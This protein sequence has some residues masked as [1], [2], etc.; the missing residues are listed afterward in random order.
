M[1]LSNKQAMQ[2]F[3]IAKGTLGITS[4]VGNFKQKTRLIII[5]GIQAQQSE[6]L[7]DLE[8]KSK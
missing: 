7:K 8:W 5:N 6:E 1:K 4:I 2:L 3:A